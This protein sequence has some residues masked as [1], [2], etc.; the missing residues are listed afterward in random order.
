V[1][2]SVGSFYAQSTNDEYRMPSFLFLNSCTSCGCSSCVCHAH[3]Y[4]TATR[5]L[6]ACAAVLQTSRYMEKHPSA[7]WWVALHSAFA[8][9]YLA[10]VRQHWAYVLSR[11]S[12]PRLRWPQAARRSGACSLSVRCQHS[13]TSYAVAML[14]AQLPLDAWKH[15]DMP[16]SHALHRAPSACACQLC[17]LESCL[18]GTCVLH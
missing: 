4:A 15:A 6:R 7:P 14:Q 10:K 13:R 2:D 12:V 17:I 11:R 18:R 3:K 8:C 5:H 16:Y 1:P 9:V